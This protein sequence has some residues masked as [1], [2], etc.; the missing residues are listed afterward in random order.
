MMHLRRS[1]TD[2]H[3]W[4]SRADL[5]PTC[6][7]SL[8]QIDL[9]KTL[10]HSHDTGANA[11]GSCEQ[12]SLIAHVHVVSTSVGLVWT[13]LYAPARRSVASP[14][15][16]ASSTILAIG[17]SC[18]CTT[19][20]SSAHSQRYRRFFPEARPHSGHAY[21]CLPT[22]GKSTA[23][24]TQLGRVLLCNRHPHVPKSSITL[25][26]EKIFPDHLVNLIAP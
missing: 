3:C 5:V 23:P 21:T 9:A 1:L 24:G 15:A 19:R 25:R 10:A 11:A 16:M 18:A 4:A 6:R 22:L 26:M 20:Y 14:L 12:T 17:C 7:P 13:G 2:R 8:M